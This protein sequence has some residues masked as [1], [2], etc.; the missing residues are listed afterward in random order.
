MARDASA[1]NSGFRKRISHP[2]LF[3]GGCRAWLDATKTQSRISGKNFF[4]RKIYDFV[5][6]FS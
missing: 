1:E 3:I 4:G 6:I 5:V 2:I